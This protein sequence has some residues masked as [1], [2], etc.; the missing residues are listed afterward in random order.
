M[1]A[2]KG[3]QQKQQQEEEEEEDAAFMSYSNVCFENK[4][5]C[6]QG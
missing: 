3:Q 1:Q 2:S 6:R 5:S 4:A